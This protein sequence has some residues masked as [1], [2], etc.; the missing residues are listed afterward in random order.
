MGTA[1]DRHVVLV[2]FMGAGKTTL[3]REAAR[4]TGLGFADLDAAVE[5]EVGD[6]IPDFFASHGETEFRR[7]ETELTVRHLEHEPG[8]IVSLGGGAVTSP[9]VRDALGARAVTVWVEVDADTAWERVRG[10][11]RP[12]AQDEAGFRRLFEERR[13][14]Y[15][16]VADVTARDVDGVVLAAGGVHVETGALGWLGELVPGE[17]PV[18]LV[19]DRHV[20]G[21]YGMEAQLGL[22]SREVAVH[23]VPAGE[24]AKTQKVLERIWRALAAGAQRHAR[25]ARRRV[26]HGR[27]RPCGCHLPPRDRLGRR[28]DDPGRPGRRSDR[29]QDGDRPP[30][31]QEPRRRLPLARRG[32]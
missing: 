2:G 25:G 31:G 23:E 3:G 26:D 6:S 8:G 16:E 4:R 22:G 9:A 30:R 1:L 15:D 17:G 18:A 32:R 24:E 14:V 13:A 27:R 19:A 11:D 21:I 28:P 10:T 29:R 7:I 5:H 12:L 20:A